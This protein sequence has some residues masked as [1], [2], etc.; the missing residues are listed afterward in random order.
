[1]EILCKANRVILHYV[2]ASFDLF[3]L[4]DLRRVSIIAGHAGKA[5]SY[6]QNVSIEAYSICT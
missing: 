6:I 1:M 4:S 2:L 3:T 5:A